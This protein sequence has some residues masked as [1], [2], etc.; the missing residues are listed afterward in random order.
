MS[1]DNTEAMAVCAKDMVPIMNR[2]GTD[3]RYPRSK[4]GLL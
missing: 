1:S 4:D 2:A 3:P